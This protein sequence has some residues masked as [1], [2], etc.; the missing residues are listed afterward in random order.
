MTQGWQFSAAGHTLPQEDRDYPEWHL[1]RTHYGVW[2]IDADTS[3]VRERITQAQAH[4]APLLVHHQRQPHITLFVCGFMADVVAHGDDFTPAMLAA[5]QAALQALQQE[6]FTL[7]IGAI[8]SFDSA[9]FLR[10]GD[11]DNGLAPLRHALGQ[12]TREIRQSAYVPHLTVGLYSGAF[13]TQAVVGQLQSFA[14]HTPIPLRVERVHFARYEARVL[15][16]PLQLCHTHALHT[17]R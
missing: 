13:D 14:P 16:G 10:V 4:L 1:G 7:Q 6:P 15:G 2:L 9:V 12:G 3:A 17:P 5:Q 11:P 8:D